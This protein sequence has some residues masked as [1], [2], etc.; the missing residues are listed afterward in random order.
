MVQRRI[1]ISDV[2]VGVP[3]PWDV[4]DA[5]GILLL[6]RGHVVNEQRQVEALIERGL[7]VDFPGSGNMRRSYAPILPRKEKPSVLRLINQANKRLEHVLRNLAA[8]PDAEGKILEITEIIRSAIAANADIALACILLN[9]IPG[10]YAV[11]HCTDT[12]IVSIL[13]A[14]TMQ[15]PA[16]EIMSI[17]AAAL[18]MN[19]SMQSYHDRLQKREGTL[20]VREIAIMRQHPQ[21]GV[22][23]LQQAG[24]TDH[25]WLSYVLHHHENEDGSGY[26]GGLSGQD[27][28]QNAKI[29]ALADRYC[30]RV[31]DRCYRK[32]LLPN[33]ALRDIFIE[34]GRSIDP[35]LASYFIKELGLYPPGTLV[36]LQNQE[37]GVVTRKGL[38]A[39][40]PIVHTVISPDDALLQAPVRRDTGNEVYAIRETLHEKKLTMRFEMRFLW[41]EEATP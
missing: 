24:I 16:A 8:E 6:H 4:F 23:A 34:Q 36:R 37:I 17:A 15:K 14:Q 10:P 28:P 33:I 1:G 41:G 39:T 29:I 11:R 21:K 13:V 2:T 20:S 22:E 31:S 18:T 38:T 26:P 35:L 12:A 5:S 3:L 19:V 25:D 7:Y 32:S 30:A 9:Q 40:T 27:I